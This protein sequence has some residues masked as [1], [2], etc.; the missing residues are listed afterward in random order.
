M[1]CTP[2]S[3]VRPLTCA[4]RGCP[5]PCTT[6]VALLP[7]PISVHTA[8]TPPLRWTP[9]TVSLLH[10]WAKR[11]IHKG[12]QAERVLWRFLIQQLSSKHTELGNFVQHLVQVTSVCKDG[13]HK[14]FLDL[15][16]MPD[17]ITAEIPHWSWEIKIG[18]QI[19]RQLYVKAGQALAFLIKRAHSTGH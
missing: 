14:A 11:Y 1:C 19:K 12:I 13:N 6:S 5:S 10:T 3:T 17:P 15:V 4:H 18:C 9:A 8:T 2:G 7:V 16:S